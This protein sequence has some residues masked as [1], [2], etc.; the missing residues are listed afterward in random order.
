M[1]MGLMTVISTIPAVPAGDTAVIDV[2][3]LAVEDAAGVE[4]K[5]TAVVPVN[6]LPV[7]VTLVP[8]SVLPETAESPVLTGVE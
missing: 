6:P 8:P 1:P 3:P 5:S 7:M 2:L 4:P